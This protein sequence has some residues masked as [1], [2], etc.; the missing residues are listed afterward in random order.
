[1]PSTPP[2]D[3]IGGEQG[4]VVAL[5]LAGKGG[6]FLAEISGQFGVEWVPWL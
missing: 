3:G 4:A 6:D 5:Q 1:L 2:V